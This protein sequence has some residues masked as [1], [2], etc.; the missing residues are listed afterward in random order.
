[1]S[2]MLEQTVPEKTVYGRGQ[3]LS[4]SKKPELLKSFLYQKKTKKLKIE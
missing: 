3:K 1:M 2:I 4:K